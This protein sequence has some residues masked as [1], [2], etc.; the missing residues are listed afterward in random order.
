MNRIAAAALIP[1][2]VAC[3]K[4]E[5]DWNVTKTSTPATVEASH[6]QDIDDCADKKLK[7]VEG[8]ISSTERDAKRT[9]FR[10][11]CKPQFEDAKKQHEQHRP[12]FSSKD[13]CERD[14]GT[15]KCEAVPLASSSTGTQQ[16][17]QSSFAPFFMGWMVANMLSNS[18]SSSAAT[19]PLYRTS[20]NNFVTPSGSTFDTATRRVESSAF[21][22]PAATAVIQPG[23][24]FTDTV[25]PAP[26]PSTTQRYTPPAS[27]QETQRYTPPT[28]N[29]N[30]AA[31]QPSRSV[32]APAPQQRAAPT[33][34]P[35]PQRA[36]PA[37]SPAARPYSPSPS[38]SG[39]FG[40]GGGGPR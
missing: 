12:R 34:A 10:E 7:A 11:Q 3:G 22:A 24:T 29:Q 37:P 26:Q 9:T 40:G 17:Q 35:A 19:T 2:M 27:K 28:A 5:D 39:G 38:R 1:F 13:D 4:K 8:T 36:A 15:G 25:K 6:Y 23:K 18:G 16:T 33:P 20:R 21:R 31:G 14:F 30:S 32:P